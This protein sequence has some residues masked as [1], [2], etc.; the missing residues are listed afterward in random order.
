[1]E[2]SHLPRSKQGE[3]IGRLLEKFGAADYGVSDA[4]VS[5]RIE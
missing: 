4:E 5:Q 2:V 1:M 3:L